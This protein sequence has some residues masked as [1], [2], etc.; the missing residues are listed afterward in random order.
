MSFAALL[1]R[2]FPPPSVFRQVL[3]CGRG[4]GQSPCR[5]VPAAPYRGAGIPCSLHAVLM[6][7][8]TGHCA[9]GAGVDFGGQEPRSKPEHSCS[10][11]PMLAPSCPAPALNPRISHPQFYWL[12]P[13]A[14]GRTCALEHLT[15]VL[16]TCWGQGLGF[17]TAGQ[18]AWLTACPQSH[19]QC[20]QLHVSI[21]GTHSSIPQSQGD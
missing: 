1:G 2:H 10:S 13:K 18:A 7:C 20:A 17:A 14:A 12:S 11:H 15:T 6:E 3:E 21:S 5:A 8:S 16:P 19:R 9:E 4:W